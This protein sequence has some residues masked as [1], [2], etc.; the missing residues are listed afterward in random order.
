MSNLNNIYGLSNSCPS[1]NS[2]GRGIFTNFKEKHQITNELKKDLGVKTST[3]FRL[4]LQK[5]GINY[6]TENQFGRLNDVYCSPD[7]HGEVKI[8]SEI[9]L[10]NGSEK[11]FADAFKPIL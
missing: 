5:K 8:D 7:P 9:N 3:E 2:D 11:T 10:N 4:Q 6:V 1:F